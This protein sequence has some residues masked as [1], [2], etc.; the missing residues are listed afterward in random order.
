MACLINSLD[1]LP[2]SVSMDW[3]TTE[4]DWVEFA[5]NYVCVANGQEVPFDGVVFDPDVAVIYYSTTP[6]GDDFIEITIT[7]GPD[8]KGLKKSA[9]NR[10]ISAVVNGSFYPLTSLTLCEKSSGGKT[11]CGTPVCDEGKEGLVITPTST[12][13]GNEY[14]GTSDKAKPTGVPQYSLYLELDTG[15]FY[16]YDN[17]EWNEIPCGG[18]SKSGEAKIIIDNSNGDV[19]VSNIFMGP[20]E[21]PPDPNNFVP[22][23]TLSVISEYDTFVELDASDFIGQSMMI[24]NNGDHVINVTGVLN[25]IIDMGNLNSQCFTMRSGNTLSIINYGK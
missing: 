21:F 18:G 7:S 19:D 8:T 4:E 10:I 13:I 6:G 22:L 16:Y 23:G 15:K 14:A 2:K 17:G 24:G 20:C 9:E 1:E 11:I 3:P 25:E 12:K 5:Q